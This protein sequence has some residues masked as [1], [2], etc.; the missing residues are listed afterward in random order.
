MMS[1]NKKYPVLKHLLS[2]SVGILLLWGLLNYT[3]FS[4]SEFFKRITRIPFG[5]ILLILAV[6]WLFVTAN[7]ARWS[8]IVRQISGN[9]EFPKGFFFYYV[10][11]SYLAIFFV[12][13]TFG[14]I[15]V[16]SLSLKYKKDIK[17]IDGSFTV[18]MEH[19]LNVLVILLMLLPSF[20]YVAKILPAPVA[21]G[22]S[23]L[24]LLLVYVLLKKYYRK[25]LTIIARTLSLIKKIAGKLPLIKKLTDT[26][27]QELQFTDHDN[28]EFIVK[29][30]A[31][32]VVVYTACLLRP[33]IYTFALGVEVPL[34]PFILAYPFVYI[35]SAV[36][37]TPGSLGLTE[38]GY[39]GMLMML[40]IG[41]E[42]AALFV[43]GMR[44]L[45]I[46]SMLVMFAIG[47]LYYTYN[48]WRSPAAFRRNEYEV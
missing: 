29:L 37:I 46:A 11:I 12:S 15:G 21:A 42:E 34:L 26:Q 27:S 24:F 18:V 32:S 8:A 20:L 31:L 43:V 17:I 1:E 5:F 25:A 9:R 35:I 38:L 19:V 3:G 23:L 41:K 7:A 4:F 16:K 40:G 48:Q 39:V 6:T 30:F 33:Y 22:L 28:R 10:S 13:G 2:L 14:N 47:Y 44:L 36:G 45:N